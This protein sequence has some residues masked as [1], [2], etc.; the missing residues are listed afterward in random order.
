MN[1]TILHRWLIAALFLLAPPALAQDVAEVNKIG[2]PSFEA[3]EPAYWD[4]SGNGATW[5]GDVARSAGYSLKLS[6]AGASAWTMGEAVRNWTDFIGRHVDGAFETGE[7]EISAYVKAE[8]VNT[9]PA[10]DDAKFQMV[11]EFFDAP[12][13]TNIPG[14]PVVVDLPQA[15]AS[16]DW[17]RVSTADL[18]AISL[19]QAA[20]SV[21]I[22]FRKGAGATGT[23][24]LDDLA[25]SADGAW[26]GTIHNGNVDAGDGWYYFTPD[27]EG[28]FANGQTWM[29]TVTTEEAHTGSRS[30]KIMRVGD[31][32]G[33]A[34]HISPRVEVTPNEPVLVSFWVKREGNEAPDEIGTGD[35]N[36]GLT[37]LW[38]ENMTA[39]ADGYGEV[40]GV[41]IRLNGEYNSQ[42]IPQAPKVADNGWTQY[43]FV[44]TPPVRGANETPVVGMEL[45]LRYWHAFTGTTYWDDVFVG[46]VADVT[47]AL[48]S[49]AEGGGFESDSPSYW[50]AS[51]DGAQWTSA[52]ARSQGYSLAL[53]GSGA[54]S[55]TMDEVVRN[56]NGEFGAG[57][58][59]FKAYVKADGVNTNPASDDA[60][61]Q[62]VVEFF[63]APGGTN[64]LGQPVVVDLPQ[65]EASTDWTL[66]STASVGAISLPQAAKSARI[67]FRKGPGAS[68]TMYIDDIHPSSG[69]IFNG[70]VDISQPWYYWA[71]DALGGNPNGQKFLNTVSPLAAFSGD[72][73][74]R[75]MR[76]DGSEG[77]TVAVSDRVA[78]SPGEPVLVSFRMRTAGN[79]TPEEI[80]T[81][82]N[83][84]GL[85][86]LWYTNLEAGAAGWGEVG[87]F[88]VRFNGEYNDRVIPRLM[89]DGADTDWRHYAVVA[90]PPVRGATEEPVV[91]ME[92]RLRY[93][94]AFTG[95]AHFD[96]VH[97]T[98]L[99]GADLV[100]TSI[101]DA[102]LPSAAEERDGMLLGNAPNPFA[103][104]TAIAFEL[105]AATRVTLE[106]YDAL[107]RRVATLL[108]RAPMAAGPHAA[109]FD[110]ANL[111]SGVYLYVLRTPEAT[112]TG[113]MTLIR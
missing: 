53:G 43:S 64:I 4:A 103:R 48:G 98:P 67:T 6:G 65:S 37:A 76:L 52:E 16:Y 44:V 110:S 57:E 40:G 34:V 2:N 58:I 69:T 112:D 30:L 63:D 71:P 111:P 97:I 75:I 29:N 18:G 42:V 78:V 80:G 28:Q 46:N 86:G 105:P 60:K 85:T 11:V 36:I 25:A 23:M 61:F 54:A 89:V 45:R 94:H 74:L 33:E 84:V 70:N 101:P 83:N 88:D 66:V 20:R 24:Y 95:E 102:L 109:T 8:G 55:W 82:D 39:G 3:S 9:N 27:A 14:Q 32:G 13:G 5:A 92:L 91:G 104:H 62:M 100:A 68:G 87:G 10:S 56:W 72:R 22:S 7:I 26:P 51:G 108:D 1:K 96:D 38:Y 99:G 19:P 79:E 15:S 17:T 81:G 106:V 73:G 35:N 77:E 47:D 49:V 113:S 59:E 21:R 31:A 90:Y 93:W 107:G 12:G 50:E 41:D